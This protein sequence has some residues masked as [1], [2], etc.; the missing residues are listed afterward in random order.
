M[1]TKSE[2]DAGLQTRFAQLDAWAQANGIPA[3]TLLQEKHKA[4]TEYEAN[5]AALPSEN[6]SAVAP[7]AGT[8]PTPS[9]PVVP[10]SAPAQVPPQPVAPQQVAKP[11]VQVS[12]P[13][14]VQPVVP[15]QAA[16]QA[17]AQAAAQT[18]IVNPPM[19]PNVPAD[20]QI[21]PEKDVIRQVSEKGER[22]ATRDL[23]DAVVDLEPGSEDQMTIGRMVP[24]EEVIAYQQDRWA[25]ESA[26]NAE[27]RELV[28]EHLRSFKSK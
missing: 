19:P 28:K 25:K 11:V 3:E 15:P 17:A 21:A 8:S 1:T 13:T 27:E 14:G 10:Q 24:F 5:V 4:Q 6:A 7:L 2:L 9:N 18:P 20:A 22:D 26:K 23:P 16:Q 12:E